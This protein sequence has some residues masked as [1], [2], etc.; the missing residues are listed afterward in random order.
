MHDLVRRA[1]FVIDAR[2]RLAM[3]RHD[4]LRLARDKD[5]GERTLP[6]Q[7]ATSWW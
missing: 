4:G 7:G 6:Y 1:E 3:F 5:L 2:L